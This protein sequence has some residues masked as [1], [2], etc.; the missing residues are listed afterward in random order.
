MSELRAWVEI[1]VA[2]WRKNFALINADKARS[3]RIAAVLKDDAYGHGALQGAQLALEAGVA[4]IA[5][6]TLDEALALRAA[7]IKAPILILG[8][9]LPSEVDEC[10]A[11]DLTI[12]LHDAAMTDVVAEKAEK[13]GLRARV[14]LEVDTGMSRYGSR[15]TEA[16]A[17]PRSRSRLS[18]SKVWNSKE[19]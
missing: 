15:W 14:H 8:Q 12:C 19:R 13:R 7:G 10:L 16:A 1:D 2:A 3:L 18:N 17:L 11:N 9:R 4:F 5:V 6:V